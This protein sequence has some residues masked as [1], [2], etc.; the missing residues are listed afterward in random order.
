MHLV[1][2]TSPD[3]PEQRTEI[4]T[5]WSPAK[6]MSRREIRAL[7]EHIRAE[8]MPVDAHLHR[9]FDEQGPENAALFALAAIVA[10]RP[11]DI[12]EVVRILPT[13][14]NEAVMVPALAYHAGGDRVTAL[15]ELVE[16]DNMFYSRS[17]LC[18]YVVFE[19]LGKERPP[20]LLSVLRYYGR[21]CGK[22][23]MLGH[24]IGKVEDP[25]VRRIGAIHLRFAQ[26]CGDWLGK[27]QKR[28]AQIIKDP[29]ACLPEQGERRVSGFTVT[30]PRSIG[31]N[32]PCPCKSG[33]KYKKCCQ[34]R[35]EENPPEPSPVAGLDRA[36]YQARI[37]EFLSPEQ[38][39][40]LDMHEMLECP[41]D[42]LP[43]AYQIAALRECAVWGHWDH[44][45]RLL[46]LIDTPS[47]APLEMDMLRAELIM[48]AVSCKEAKALRRLLPGVIK[49]GLLRPDTV[50]AVH[51]MLPSAQ[52]VEILEAFLL[53]GLKQAD[54]AL[55]LSIAK[56]V[57][58]HFPA[59]GIVLCRGSL[60]PVGE[61][62]L[63]LLQTIEEARDR[64]NL[65]PGDIYAKMC[66]LVQD[67]GRGERLRSETE[68]YF[69]EEG[70]R[71]REKSAE[72]DERVRKA[73]ERAEAL[74]R[75]LE[76]AE[77]ELAAA[78]AS[79]REGVD[80]AEYGRVQR[81]MERL[82]DSIR[83]GRKERAALQQ[84]LDARSA[85]EK[86]PR[87]PD[88]GEARPHQPPAEATG[89]LDDADE[90]GPADGSAEVGRRQV[91]PP[92]LSRQ[93]RQAL[94]ELPARVSHDALL[95]LA[96]LSSGDPV[97]WEQSKRLKE[98]TLWSTRVAN[99][100]RLLFRPAERC[101]EILDLRH[102]KYLE[103][104]KR[105]LRGHIPEPTGPRGLSP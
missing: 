8:D 24:L 88:E 23:A 82:K 44:A 68:K 71:L 105:R 65:P 22:D 46:T 61:K 37:H 99:R 92:V 62:S 45:E 66:A 101:L 90:E 36:A 11:P 53:S 5:P 55:L 67:V 79:A 19:L 12:R 98:T 77:E 72:S 87:G 64:L 39:G 56:V 29:L 15:F 81:K 28:I 100:Y 86:A 4:P 9:L 14:K 49:T 97:A 54:H 16:S 51:L 13:V 26:E 3:H 80:G 74:S 1:N 102:R 38:F 83:E 40:E 57:A 52:T 48:H 95:T 18:L 96:R 17:F 21:V 41:I 47:A 7:S 89:V 63:P 6:S 73:E 30:R 2:E 50:A 43:R 104:G 10:G 85:E 31:R 91:L 76:K 34:R 59:L 84:A 60:I 33:K 103:I 93:V 58:D 25:A 27:S 35:D 20:R 94:I 42:R 78:R 75:R 32:D 69:Q 70:Q